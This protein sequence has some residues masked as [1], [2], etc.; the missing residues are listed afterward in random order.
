MTRRC[1]ALL[2]VAQRATAVVLA[3]GI[4]L[5]LARAAIDR[6]GFGLVAA[7]RDEHGPRLIYAVVAAA[8]LVHGAIGLRSLWNRRSSAKRQASDNRPMGLSRQLHR[9]SGAALLVIVPIHLSVA[10]LA[11]AGVLSLDA[12]A[13]PVFAPVVEAGVVFLVLSHWGGGLRLLALELLSLS[14]LQNA[15]ASASLLLALGGAAWVLLA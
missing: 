9:L 3:I 14:R 12:L 8:A 10:A 5:H 11:V 1:E 6:P 2:W 13:R 7:L 4:A 15:L